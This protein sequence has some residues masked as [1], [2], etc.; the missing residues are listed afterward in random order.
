MV[1]GAAV[2]LAVATFF[3][4]RRARRQPYLFTGW[5]WFLGTAVPIIGLVQVGNQSIADRYAYVPLIGIYIA[6]AWS[7]AGL[8]ASRPRLTPVILAFATAALIGCAT[9]R[10][11]RSP[12]RDT[13]AL[14]TQAVAVTRDNGVARV[15]LGEEL[16]KQGQAAEAEP[17]L[18]EA[19][20][21]LP[22]LSDAQQNARN[23]LAVALVSLGRVDEAIGQ[24]AEV[25]KFS[26]DNA[27][28]HMNLAL[29]LQSQG[30]IEPCLVH[31]D[32]ALRLDPTNAQGHAAFAYLL[33]TLR[34]PGKAMEH[35]RAAL[36]VE[37]DA[38]DT[39][40]NLANL[41]AT[42]PS[43]EFRDGAEAVHLAERASALTGH[44]EPLPMATLAA[45]YAEAGRFE[46]AI[47]TASAAK[48]LAIQR[49]Q[50]ELAELTETHL[51]LYQARR[52]LRDP[53]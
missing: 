22:P 33:S 10:D 38:I 41:L 43:A 17:H 36:R 19:V 44:Q 3:A 42:D 14:F 23:N 8:L 37:P 24:Y 40:N 28:A 39:L 26:P 20:R 9:C 45:A 46:D 1:S 29:A 32:A 21:L 53:R 48:H 49:G 16:L 35:Y 52:P 51:Q 5:F 6:I 50:P 47:R 4:I 18:R 11:S 31:Y 7:V 25:L 13:V 30:Q 15:N 12:L 2:A 27:A 34:Q